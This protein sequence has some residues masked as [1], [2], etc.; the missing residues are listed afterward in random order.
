MFKMDKH[1]DSIEFAKE[2]VKITKFFAGVPDSLL[3]HLCS[4]LERTLPAGNF[5]T[6]ANEGAAVALAAGYTLA[7]GLPGAVYMQNSGLG[8]AVNPLLSLNDPAVYGIPV[9]LIVGWRGEPGVPDEP[10][11]KKQGLV[12]AELLEVCN[13]PYK[14]LLK[15]MNEAKKALLWAKDTMETTSAPVALLIRKDILGTV[16]CSYMNEYHYR[17]E[18]AIED[19]ISCLSG[20]ELIVSTTGMI[21]RELC[22]LRTRRSES[23]SRDFPVV[24]SMGHASQVALGLALG[25][26]NHKIICLD[27]DG[28]AIMHMGSMT[29]ISRVKPPNMLHIMLNNAAHDSVGGHPTGADKV[30]WVSLALACGY[31]R[32][33][34]AETSE[35]T[36]KNIK[37][38]LAS[39]KCCF[40]EVKVSQGARADLGRPA[41]SP[42][43]LK[44]DFMGYSSRDS[45][46]GV[47]EMNSVPKR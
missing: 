16:E 2:L 15:N 35:G 43:E 3:K 17:R 7:T 9:L 5:W 33:D 41:K 10:Q 39:K 11:H 23:G 6:T 25:K 32:A 13:I 14:I 22:E 45:E 37:E 18:A 28:S 38:M 46:A 30:D 29:T 34:S 1:L 21:S 12:T 40:L 36:K 27:G 19:I 47:N 8:N 44:R 24:G 26:P 20:G 31:E 42:T 4:A